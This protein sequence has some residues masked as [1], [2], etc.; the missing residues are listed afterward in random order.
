VP[1]DLIADVQEAIGIAREISDLVGVSMEKLY[2]SIQNGN[3]S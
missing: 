1:V 2:E 3:P